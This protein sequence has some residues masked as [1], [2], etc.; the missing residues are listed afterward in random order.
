[1]VL[2]Y[3]YYALEQAV[4]WSFDARQSRAYFG[5]LR[6][7]LDRI[8][9]TPDVQIQEDYLFFKEALVDWCVHRPPYSERLF[10]TAQME[11]IHQ[12]L[13]RRWVSVVFFWVCNHVTH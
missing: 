13:Y 1:M 4:R 10:S 12:Y 5:I 8:A 6:K 3:Y 9:G 2:D 7:L 11:A